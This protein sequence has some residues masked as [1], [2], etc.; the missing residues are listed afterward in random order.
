MDLQTLFKER[1]DRIEVNRGWSG[2]RRMVMSYSLVAASASIAV[3]GLMVFRRLPRQEG[4]LRW[5]F[6]CLGSL[7]VGLLLQYLPLEPLSRVLSYSLSGVKSG[8]W[9]FDL[10]EL[11]EVVFLTLI[12]LRALSEIRNPE[13]RELE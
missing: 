4:N 9:Q 7:L 12:G 3:G 13:P 6:V 2:Q 8:V 1:F 5:A 10:M 11:L